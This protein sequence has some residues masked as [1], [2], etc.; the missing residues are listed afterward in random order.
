[1]GKDLS[2]VQAGKSLLVVLYETAP[3]LVDQSR[4]V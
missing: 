2:H 1:M 3:L 4:I